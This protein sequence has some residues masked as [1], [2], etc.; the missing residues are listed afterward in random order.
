[1]RDY[2]I[3][4]LERH[5]ATVRGDGGCTVYFPGFMPYSLLLD[6]SNDDIDTRVNN[7]ANFFHWCGSRILTLDR[8]YAKEIL[9]SLGLRQAVTDRDR[10]EIAISYHAV[11]LTDVYWV[12]ETG[13]RISY[14]DINLYQHSLSYAEGERA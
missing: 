13:E 5:V 10:A 3:M 14:G 6:T 9:N 12:R 11:S 4:H 8:R 2:C 7:L 1:M